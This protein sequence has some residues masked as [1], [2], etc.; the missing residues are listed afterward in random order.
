MRI[1]LT[2]LQITG[3]YYFIQEN[4]SESLSKKTKTTREYA[5]EIGLELVIKSKKESK[6]STTEG[7]KIKKQIITK[8]EQY[9]TNLEADKIEKYKFDFSSWKEL[10]FIQQTAIYRKCLIQDKVNPEID[11]INPK[12]PQEIEE[13]ME[14]IKEKL[15]IL[16]NLKFK[17]K[18]SQEL[19]KINPNL[20]VITPY[21]VRKL[22][23][24]S[25]TKP[26]YDLLKNLLKR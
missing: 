7:K 25:Q 21:Q 14:D 22:R 24:N 19:K 15:V 10:G 13:I 26:F 11:Q 23:Q 6:I 9:F 2:E 1:E 18:I 17:N 16:Y 3:F 5:Q 12:I 8:M 4:W 20:L